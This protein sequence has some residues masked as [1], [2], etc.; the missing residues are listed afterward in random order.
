MLGPIPAAAWLLWLAFF[1]TK[2]S[3][4]VLRECFGSDVF[5]A[6]AL[7]R[8]MSPLLIRSVLM[9][10]GVAAT[11]IFGTGC[12]ASVT[13]AAVMASGAG[14]IAIAADVAVAVFNMG[15]ITSRTGNAV[16]FSTAL[17]YTAE[18]LQRSGTSCAGPTVVGSSFATLVA[19]TLASI[20]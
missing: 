2:V 11:R 13:T 9:T 12:P 17:L 15:R 3:A 20:F 5:G 10:V 14:V 4:V 8:R 16:I 19:L 1:V 6:R 18:A 7:A